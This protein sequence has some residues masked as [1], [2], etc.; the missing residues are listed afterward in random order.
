M[1]TFEREHEAAKL[2][3]ADA[4]EQSEQLRVA[5]GGVLDLFGTLCCYPR[6]T[7]PV[8]WSDGDEWAC[9]AHREQLD[10]EKREQMP[11]SDIM[12]QACEAI[13]R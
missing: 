8:T 9:H 13:G 5:L 3:L 10:L 2:A 6:C 1:E 12:G 4:I 7:S 11:W